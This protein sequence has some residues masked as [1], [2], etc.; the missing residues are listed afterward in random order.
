M[1]DLNYGENYNQE[2]ILKHEIENR[3][4]KTF[5]VL[6]NQVLLNYGSNSNLIMF[7]SAFS[8]KCLYEKKRPLKVLLDFPNYFLTV[9][10]L[11]QWF[12]EKKI[13]TRDSEMN[14]Q[15]QTF[16][17]SIK[18]YN[19]DIILLTTPNNPT[20]KP[21]KD[22]EIKKIIDSAP[23]EAIFLIDRSCV[24]VLKEISTKELLDLYPTRKIVI[25][26]SFSKSH[27]LANERLG[28]LITNNVEI[29]NFLYYK[30]DMNHNIHAVTKCLKVLNNEN[31]KKQKIKQ[32]KESLDLIKIF[33]K[34]YDINCYD[35]HSNFV[36]IKLPN[37]LNAD[38]IED[39]M[40]KKEILIMNGKNIGLT[41][42]Y[43]RLHMSGKKDVQTFI[44]EFEK[45][46]K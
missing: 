42:E 6:P 38:Y 13:I 32:I 43:L 20:G 26:H 14:F 30:R 1:I 37:N 16:L 19:P 39:F 11:N 36:L 2:I 33:C 41:N 4:A 23:K 12:I 17:D 9:S 24:N 34:K 15:L 25:L 28:Y 7:F 45:I 31:L 46:L 29:A 21:L 44:K 3:I 27:S 40:K 35:S 10:Q 5:N 22:E 8:V 18:E